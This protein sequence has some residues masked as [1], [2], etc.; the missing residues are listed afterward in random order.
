VHPGAPAI[1]RPPLVTVLAVL[2]FIGAG[3]WLMTALFALAAVAAGGSGTALATAGVVVAGLGVLQLACGVGLWKLRPHGRTLQLVFAWVG[4]LGIPIGTIISVLLLIYFLKP[5]VK[6]LF[7][8]KAAP[9]LTPEELAQVTALSRSSSAA[10]VL[11]VVV[12]FGSIAGLGFVAAI[13]VPGLLRARIS[14]N[15][16]AALATL[17]AINSAQV[18]FAST[19]G[20][21]FYAPDLASLGIAPPGDRGPFLDPELARDPL[22]QSGYTVALVAGEPARDVPVACNGTPVVASYFA[23]ADPE[24]PGTTG[25]RFFATNQ[26]CRLFQSE[27]DIPVTHTGVPEGATLVE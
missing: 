24:R 17:R 26:D 20:H 8:G 3:L 22:V 13:A 11:V 5:G 12:I 27:A 1:E 25:L 4:L 23:G 2:H 9:E 6:A 15:E 10:V 18:T 14:G 21:G 19:C 7:S 16:A